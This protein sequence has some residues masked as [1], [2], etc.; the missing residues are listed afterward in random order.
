MEPAEIGR[1]RIDVDVC[2]DVSFPLSLT[3]GSEPT[4][5]WT[6]VDDVTSPAALVERFSLA[7]TR[8]LIEPLIYG[9]G[10]ERKKREKSKRRRI[11]RKRLGALLKWR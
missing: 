2:L 9:E 4:G 7:I 5:L 8:S 3:P 10:G 6:F 1:K 11:L